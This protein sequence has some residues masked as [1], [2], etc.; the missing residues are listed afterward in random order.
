MSAAT[1][2]I[3]L[4]GGCFWCVEAVFQ[5]REGVLEVDSGYAGGA[6]T[7]P[8]YKDICDGYTGHAEVVR[9][10][11]DSSIVT[12]EQILEL[13]WQAHDPTTPNRQGADTGT[14]YRSIIL[15][16]TPEQRSLAEHSKAQAQAAFT[17][18]IV[19]EIKPLE[20]FWPAEPEHQDFYRRNGQHM[21]CTYNI[22]PKLDKL[23]KLGLV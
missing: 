4:G 6:T 17:A 9:I 5:Q 12:L 20:R 13:F 15:T 16:A 18:P 23:K 1:E 11:F 7:N 3:V 2:E 14:Q 22:V 8:T 10:R 21:Y 19:T